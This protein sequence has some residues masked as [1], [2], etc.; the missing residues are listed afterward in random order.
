MERFSN[1]SMGETEITPNRYR[2]ATLGYDFQPSVSQVVSA[3]VEDVYS[4]VGSLEADLRASAVVSAE[5]TGQVITEDEY[6]NSDYYRP[7]ISYYNAMTSESAK[8]LAE[9]QDDVDRRAF[10]ISRANGVQN[11]AGFLGA[12]SAGIFEPKN[13]AIGVGT[14]IVGGALANRVIAAKRIAKLKQKYGKYKTSAVIGGTEGLVAATLAEP[15][16]RESAR[17]LKQDYDLVDSLFNVALSTTLG[18]G[19][20]VGGSYIAGKFKQKPNDAVDIVIEELD[21]ATSQLAEGRKIDV[22]AVEVLRDG[23]LA[24]KPIDIKAE[25]AEA[26]VRYTETP[27]FKAR[28]EGSKVVDAEGNPLRVYHGTNKD[29]AAFKIGE[30]GKVENLDELGAYFTTNVKEANLY[31]EK[32]GGNV[33]PAYLK[34]ENPKII[35][36]PDNIKPI[37][38]IDYNK[39]SKFKEAFDAGNDG[40]IVKN[41][42]EQIAVAFS[43]EQIIPAF[44]EG[45]LDSIVADIDA[46][47]VKK[48]Q[49][50]IKENQRPDNSTVYDSEALNTFDTY[51]KSYPDEMTT[52]QMIE[53][54]GE[55]DLL[56]EQG[57]LDEE[58]L[59][60]LDD[61]AEFDEDLYNTGLDA[62]YI[63]LTRG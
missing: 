2:Q 25:K 5:E 58:S 11:V 19:L 43:P 21:T 63:C 15:S 36:V 4:G 12:L 14:S 52:E 20:N 24:R 44:G 37:E 42:K 55:I 34:M 61:L 1:A 23:D 10:V 3:Y 22:E 51:K 62:A 6:K 46:Q 49:Q 13:F 45:K 54:E 28:F 56:R 32:A 47:N 39:A 59:R 9:N 57:L 31:A 18:A 17:I 35:E 7:N 53:L 8:I 16:N 40:I 30:M 48:T 33:R 60:A 26:F 38:E 41:S 29:F 27:E 50:T